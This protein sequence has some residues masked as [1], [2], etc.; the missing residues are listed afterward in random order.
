MGLKYDFYS[1]IIDEI[2]YVTWD[3]SQ[4]ENEMLTIFFVLP[5]LGGV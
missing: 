4:K 1:S 5:Q 3:Y 2:L